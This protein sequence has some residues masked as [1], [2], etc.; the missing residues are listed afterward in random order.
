[1]DGGELQRLVVAKDTCSRSEAR[2]KRFLMYDKV[3]CRAWAGAI[4]S[5]DRSGK[6]KY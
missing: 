6:H 4:R 1:M 5:S 2:E 3:C